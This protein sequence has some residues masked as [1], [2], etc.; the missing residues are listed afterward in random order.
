MD[1]V[2][3]FK[4][5][6]FESL[7]KELQPRLYAYSRKFIDDPETARDLV[8]DAFIKFWEDIDITA[9]HTS[10]AAYLRKTVHNLC[11]LHLRSQ[12][13]HQRFENYMAFKLKEAELNFF[14]PDYGVYTSI[15]LK[16]MEDIIKKCVENLPPQSRR[17]FE[18]SRT[19]G[20]SYAEI[21]DEL[22]ISVRTVENHVYR[23]LAIMKTELHDY[24]LTLLAAYL[25]SIN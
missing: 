5:A 20:M 18:M 15:F 24:L 6:N 11:L 1:T 12:Q 17:I 25:V 9:I 4:K 7:Y 21:A 23:V 2:S 13:I 14:S 22:G 3:D 19:K 10:I 8:Q 16:D